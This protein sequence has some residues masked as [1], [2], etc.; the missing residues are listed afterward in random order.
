MILMVAQLDCTALKITPVIKSRGNYFPL[1]LQCD[2][3]KSKRHFN[4][5]KPYHQTI[6]L[7]KLNVT[8]RNKTR[9][10]LSCEL[11]MLFKKRTSNI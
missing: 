10:V 1:L 11:R 5:D 9:D 4:I 8:L 7:S 3:E 2:I 6:H